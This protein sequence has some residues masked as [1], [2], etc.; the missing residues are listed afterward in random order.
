MPAIEA[1][2]KDFNHCV[3]TYG[4]KSSYEAQIG[5]LMRNYNL[6]TTFKS[7]IA[8]YVKGLAA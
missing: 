2:K 6:D 5:V 3:E 4:D 8:Q 1:H 7:Q